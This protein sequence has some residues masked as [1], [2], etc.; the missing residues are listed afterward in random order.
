MT[1][2]ALRLEIERDSSIEQ[3]SNVQPRYS[4]PTCPSCQRRMTILRNKMIEV[5]G[6][7]SVFE[8]PDCKFIAVEGP[9]D[10]KATGVQ[11]DAMLD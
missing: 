4:F 8:C 6:E 2:V 3:V 9:A 7:T 11:I 1:T 10:R 5:D